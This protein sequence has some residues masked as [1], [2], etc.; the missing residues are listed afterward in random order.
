M[1]K[2]SDS[3]LNHWGFEKDVA[4]LKKVGLQLKKKIQ[5]GGSMGIENSV[6]Q[7]N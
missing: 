4:L 2:P 7:D 6:T 3:D 1:E 5:N